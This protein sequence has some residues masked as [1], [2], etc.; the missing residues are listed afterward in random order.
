MSDISL[1]TRKDLLDFFLGK[2]PS[3]SDNQNHHFFDQVKV[4]INKPNYDESSQIRK[5]VFE[6]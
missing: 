5:F 3:T 4:L 6:Y 2:F 1:V